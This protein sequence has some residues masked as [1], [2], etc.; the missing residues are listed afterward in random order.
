MLAA[1]SNDGRLLGWAV[2]GMDERRAAGTGVIAD[3]LARTPRALTAL[4]RHASDALD[5]DGADITTLGYRDPRRWSS[6]AVAAAG[7][8]P[9]GIA[10]PIL[11]SPVP[12]RDRDLLDVTHWYL[13]SGEIL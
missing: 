7:F 4:V 11:L 12:G 9:R 10:P 1:R 3:V 13:T 2:Y 5:R 6:A 8:V